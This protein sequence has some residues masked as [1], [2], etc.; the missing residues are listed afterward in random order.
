M[1]GKYSMYYSVYIYNKKNYT[2]FL[3]GIFQ[4]RVI[5]CMAPYKV[6]TTSFLI[7]ETSTAIAAAN[8]NDNDS[9]QSFRL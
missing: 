7:N 9:Q 3:Q 6:R 4:Q 5:M 8:D 2:E 1:E